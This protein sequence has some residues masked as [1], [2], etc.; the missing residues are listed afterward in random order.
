MNTNTVTLT[1]NLVNTP[2]ISVTQSAAVRAR[3]RLAHTDRR[4]DPVTETWQDG[5]SLFIDVTCWRRLAEHVGNS[6]QKGDRVIVFGRL[7]QWTAER[8]GI[9]RQ[10]VEV[11]AETVGPDLQRGVVTIARPRRTWAAGEDAAGGGSD[12][13]TADGL[14]GV[15]AD[16]LTDVTADG[17]DGIQDERSV[18]DI[19]A[20][21]PLSSDVGN[22]TGAEPWARPLA[23]VG[24]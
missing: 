17:V 7:R 6:L 24:G 3:F 2:E 8:D 15:T 4:R 23:E 1:G 19:S 10:V 11:E 22:E 9:R 13:V 21:A 20:D 16:G 14:S 12:D 5:D 18:G